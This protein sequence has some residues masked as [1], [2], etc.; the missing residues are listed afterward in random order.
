MKRYDARGPIWE[1][2]MRS[3]VLLFAVLSAGA[4]AQDEAGREVQGVVFADVDGDGARDAEE[5]ALPGI[6]L[7]NGRD[8]AVTNARGR[9]GIA[10]QPGDTLFL[11]KPPQYDLPRARNGLPMF[12]RHEIPAGSPALKYG[13]LPATRIGSGDFGLLPRRAELRSPALD[14]LV[15]G[16][17]Q[18]KRRED[19]DYFRRDIVEPLAGA[20]NAQFGLSLGDIVDDDLSLY[21]GVIAAT[22]LTGLP[23]LHVPGNH[24]LDFDAAR[25]EDSVLSWRAAFGPDTFAYEEPQASFV[26]LDDVVYQPQAARGYV[27]GLREDQFAFLEQYLATLPKARRLVLAAHIPFHDAVPG[28]QSFRR[29]DRERLFALLAPFPNVLLLTSHAHAQRHYFHG[30]ADGWKGAAPLHEYVVGAACGGFWSGLPDAQGIPD[31]RMSDGTPNGYARLRIEGPDYRLRWHVARDP[32]DTRIALYAPRTLRRGAY[33]AFA[34]TANVFMGMD[35]TRV[36][37][38]IDDGEWK[39]MTRAPRPDPALL[40]LNAADDAST[41]LRSYD[42]YVEASVSTHL[43]RGTLPTDLA[44]GEHRV[45]VRAFDRWGGELQARTSYRLEGFPGTANAHRTDAPR[46][47]RAG[48]NPGA[49]PRNAPRRDSRSRE[50]DVVNPRS[51]PSMGAG[52]AGPW[53]GAGPGVG[54]HEA[55]RFDMRSMG[56]GQPQ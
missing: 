23:W 37:Y 28:K 20:A 48:G 2:A 51:R 22:V 45:E 10:V 21:P 16:D 44:L 49:E 42:R 33:P 9:Y 27:G 7:S 30:A 29:A 46:R 38:R 19:V 55:M 47:S 35:D 54:P 36:E 52:Q 53:L 31:A 56:K 11:I 25:D 50:D 4:F 26:L 34:V 41:T 18:P 15:F 6:K 40:A 14:V 12:Y 17:P 32:A 39:P 5:P 8:V 3:A 24:D 1:A 43:W 13:G